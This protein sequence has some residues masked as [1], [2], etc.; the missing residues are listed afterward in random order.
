M[1][2][3]LSALLSICM[4]LERSN[5]GSYGFQTRIEVNY[6]TV[7]NSGNGSDV[8]CLECASAGGAA[9]AGGVSDIRIEG[10]ASAFFTR[11][12]GIALVL[13]RGSAGRVSSGDESRSGI[14]DGL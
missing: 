6:E 2:R 8:S 14:C 1:V 13:V 5:H 11:A 9:W 10:S 7:C 4:Q 12:R 3:S